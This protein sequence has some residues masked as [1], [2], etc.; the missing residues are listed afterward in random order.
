MAVWEE[1]EVT[2]KNAA[3]LLEMDHISRHNRGNK[4]KRTGIEKG[5]P[6]LVSQSD[7]RLW[8]DKLGIAVIYNV[9][10]ECDKSHIFF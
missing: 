6:G 5:K 4:G 9:F 2:I 3:L 1:K 10:V 7:G 8:Q